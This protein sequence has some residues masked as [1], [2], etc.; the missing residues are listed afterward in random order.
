MG[1]YQYKFIV[2][3]VWRYSKSHPTV[4]DNS[5]NINNIVDNS[6]KLQDL[7]YNRKSSEDDEE[8]EIDFYSK[9]KKK[10]DKI[11]EKE[12]QKGN[13]SKK[14]SSLNSNESLKNEDLSGSDYSSIFV[15]SKEEMNV[16][17]NNAPSYYTRPFYLHNLHVKD[18]KIGKNEFVQ[19]RT[20]IYADANSSFTS[21]MNLP[22]HINM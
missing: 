6:D 8:D 5:G 17:A 20:K 2:D 4:K 3:N 1:S 18:Y 10:D 19:D 16:D 14:D 22:P 13:L 15:P 11:N 9:V 7:I 21:I 12:K